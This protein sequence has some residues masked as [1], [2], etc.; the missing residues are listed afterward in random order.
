MS[1]D[2]RRE[3]NFCEIYSQRLQALEASQSGRRDVTSQRDALQHSAP[4]MRKQSGNRES[5]M[6]TNQH[7]LRFKWVRTIA[8][9]MHHAGH[10][11]AISQCV[12]AVEIRG[13]T[14]EWPRVEVVVA[15]ISA[16]NQQAQITFH[17][18][19]PKPKP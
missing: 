1:V 8:Q 9:N 10:E 16:I 15:Q 6:E 3:C 4:M 18:S 7:D 17:E 5:Q 19:I 13:P 2:R 11:C 12:E 14:R